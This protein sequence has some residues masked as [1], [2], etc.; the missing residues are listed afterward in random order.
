VAQAS[1][2]GEPLAWAGGRRGHARAEAAALGMGGGG[3]R[4]SMA[5][6]DE[7]GGV[8][9]AQTQGRRLDGGDNETMESRA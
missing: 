2:R 1:E 7:R 3:A 8:G 9:G 4:A 6:H 5:G